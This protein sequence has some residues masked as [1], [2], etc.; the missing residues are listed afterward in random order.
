MWLVSRSSPDHFGRVCTAPD[1]ADEYGVERLDIARGPKTCGDIALPKAS[2]CTRQRPQERPIIILRSEDHHDE[3][4]GY[5]IHCAKIHRGLK[6]RE[7]A[8]G[9]SN[10]HNCRMW[11]RSSPA[12]A[13]CRAVLP[14]EKGIE[15]RGRIKVDRGCPYIRQ[16]LENGALIRSEKAR[17]D[18]VRRNEIRNFHVANAPYS[19]PNHVR[20]AATI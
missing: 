6:S 14:L 10:S 15:Y 13:D 16:F 3:V 11:D 12:K 1:I 7:N 19:R 17:N 4:S 2:R 9:S 8:Y 18:P 5:A 20:V